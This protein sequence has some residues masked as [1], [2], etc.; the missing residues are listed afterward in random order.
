MTG[1]KIDILMVSESKLDD[2]FPISLF[3][4]DCT[5]NEVV[6]YFMLKITL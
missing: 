5:R 6:Y 1:N 2:T 3:V 4:I